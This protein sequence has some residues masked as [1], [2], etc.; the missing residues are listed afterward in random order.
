MTA[1][2]LDGRSLSKELQNDI[3]AEVTAFSEQ[4]GQ[5][6]CLAVIQVE[7]DD[8]SARYVRTIR[9][10]CEGA[11][12]SFTLEL[13][14]SDVTQEILEARIETLSVDPS[15]HGIL[16][17]MPLPKHIATEQAVLRLDYTKDVDGIHPVNAGLLA[18]GRPALVPNT[19]AGGLELLR[20]NTI[21]L[22]GRRAAMVGRSTIVGR[23]MAALLVQANATVTICHS[24]TSDLADILRASDIILVAIGRAGMITG[25][26]VRPGAVVVD[27]GIN[28]LED[29]SMVGDVDFASVAEV[30]S[31]ITPVPGGT[32]P[33][34]N[35]MLLRNVMIAARQQAGAA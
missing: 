26:M 19:P 22:A 14:P 4:Y 34:T 10:R 31:A 35:A 24:Y 30:A 2:L 16:I 29:G 25:D 13:L 23:P 9:K 17:Q 27:F 6:P 15:V 28:M 11:G 32:G 7:G 33:M 8:A 1:T 12:I 5:T 3:Q 21:E 20:H 18:L